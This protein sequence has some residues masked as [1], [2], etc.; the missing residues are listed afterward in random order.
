MDDGPITATEIRRSWEM[1]NASDDAKELD[2]LV[3]EVLA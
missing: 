3:G 1:F 2:R